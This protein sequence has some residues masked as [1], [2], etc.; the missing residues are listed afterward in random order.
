MDMPDTLGGLVLAFALES[1][2]PGV[3]ADVRRL[4]KLAVVAE[5]QRSDANEVNT[6]RVRR[7]F[8]SGVGGYAVYG[9]GSVWQCQRW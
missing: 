2:Q 9:L 8:D 6:G 1:E 5:E 4:V 7:G 3:R